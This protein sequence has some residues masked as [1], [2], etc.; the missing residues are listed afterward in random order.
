LT[1]SYYPQCGR[2]RR[3]SVSNGEPEN[4]DIE[5]EQLKIERGKLRLEHQKL[6]VGN[7][8]T[9]GNPEARG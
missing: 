3:E 4:F 8:Y 9:A 5:R 7:G 6:A 1:P 2:Q